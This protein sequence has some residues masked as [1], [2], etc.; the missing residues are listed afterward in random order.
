MCSNYI[1]MT[2][3]EGF[4]EIDGSDKKRS[5]KNF[6]EEYSNYTRNENMNGWD[7][8]SLENFLSPDQSPIVEGYVPT[9]VPGSDPVSIHNEVIALQTDIDNKLK[10]LQQTEGSISSEKQKYTDGL[11]YTAII[12]ASVTTTLLYFTFVKL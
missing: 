3:Y 8:L 6:N 11:T 7:A 1:F 12:W 9:I 4:T 10:E 5:L 2:N